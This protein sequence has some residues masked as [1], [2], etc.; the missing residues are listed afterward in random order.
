VSLTTSVLGWH[1]PQDFLLFQANS[2]LLFSAAPKAAK[3]HCPYVGMPRDEAG[4]SA[5]WP[6]RASRRPT[7]PAVDLPDGRNRRKG[8]LTT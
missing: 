5:A 6:L 2:I 7:P 4:L 1:C 3:R 8:V